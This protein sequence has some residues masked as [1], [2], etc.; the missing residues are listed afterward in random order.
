MS[1]PN[2]TSGRRH[3]HNIFTSFFLIDINLKSIFIFVTILFFSMGTHSQDKLD[4]LK[5]IWNDQNA[6]EVSR[7]KAMREY[8]WKGYMFSQP[9]SA[10]YF[11]QL[12]YDL[13]EL[14][15][16]KREMALALNAQ[17]VSLTMSGDYHKA[18]EFLQQSVDMGEEISDKVIVA[19]GLYNIGYCYMRQYDHFNAIDYTKRSISVYEELSEE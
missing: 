17:G 12:T 18:L 4:S 14:H 11:F 6:D 7:I 10:F 3:V 1:Y 2:N 16:L 13:A 9:D 19:K 5:I 15:G 8:A